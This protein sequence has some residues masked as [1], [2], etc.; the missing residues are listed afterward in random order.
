[1]KVYL[2]RRLAQSLLV[3]LGVSFIVFFILYLTGDPALV[4]L[5][6]DASAEDVQK[7]REAIGFNDPFIVQYNRFLL[8]AL[9][10]V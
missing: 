7:F 3:L 4:L 10:D 9:A 8:G 5:P 1:M 6:P 2:A